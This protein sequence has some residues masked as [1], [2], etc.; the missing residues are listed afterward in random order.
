M[1]HSL[2]VEFRRRAMLARGDLVITRGL[3]VLGAR[4]MGGVR[5]VCGFVQVAPPSPARLCDA[6][7]STHAERSRYAL[8]RTVPRVRS[9]EARLYGERRDP[10]PPQAQSA[11]SERRSMGRSPNARAARPNVQLPT[12]TWR[13]SR[14]PAAAEAHRRPG[15]RARL[16]FARCMFAGVQRPRSPRTTMAVLWLEAIR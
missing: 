14:Q 16:K 11:P 10:G 7:L 5:H 1:Q 4:G 6:V 12:R 3:L 9:C 8:Q 13:G 15:P 2:V